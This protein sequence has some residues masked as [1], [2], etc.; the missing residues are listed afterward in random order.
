MSSE[1]N[2]NLITEIID[3]DQTAEEIMIIDISDVEHISVIDISDVESSTI[4]EIITIEDS[5]EEEDDQGNEATQYISEQYIN[6]ESREFNYQE[7]NQMPIQYNGYGYTYNH[8]Y[9]QPMW[10]VPMTPSYPIFINSQEIPSH[11]GTP[12][13]FY[14]NDYPIDEPLPEIPAHYL[15]FF[16]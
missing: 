9:E 16:H 4:E 2:Y 13:P 15:P 1:S 6:D 5:Y 12:S 10:I 14:N 11:H 3:L 8:E 7:Y